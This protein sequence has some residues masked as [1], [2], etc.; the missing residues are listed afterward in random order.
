MCVKVLEER[1]CCVLYGV[2][3]RCI[4]FHVL[5]RRV[6]LDVQRGEGGGSLMRC[7]NKR[8]A[9]INYKEEGRGGGEGKGQRD[10]RR[11]EELPASCA[12]GRFFHI[13]RY[14]RLQDVIYELIPASF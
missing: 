13:R 1:K 8:G 14:L 4:L 2:V 10:Y 7:N 6:V 11:G 5:K 12:R 9:L 3:V